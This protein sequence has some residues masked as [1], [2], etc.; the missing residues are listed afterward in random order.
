MNNQSLMD[1]IYDISTYITESKDLVSTLDKII[2]LIR[3]LFIIDNVVVYRLIQESQDVEAIY[4]RALGRGKNAEAD[5]AW[6]ELITNKVL[7]TNKTIL[8]KPSSLNMDDRLENS[9]LLAVPVNAFRNIEGSIVYIRFGGP[10]FTSEEIKLAEIIARQVSILFSKHIIEDKY[11][12]LSDRNKQV[13][14][15]EDFISNITHEL[16]TP[17]GF[18]KGYATTL[19]RPDTSWDEANQRKFLGIIDAETDH[20]L[21]LINNLLDSSRLQ[22]GQM[23]MLFQPVQLESC[24]RDVIMRT[25]MRAASIDIKLNCIKTLIPINGDPN[26]LVQVFENIVNNALKYAPGSDIDITINQSSDHT[27]ISI[28]DHGAGIPQEHLPYLFNRFYQVKDKNQPSHG[29]GL[30]LYI[31]KEIILAHHGNIEVESKIGAG[32]E[33]II[34]IPNQQPI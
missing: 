34:T 5:V 7:Q 20:L 16:R 3:Q 18:I 29:S 21:E 19:L 10:E 12:T 25:E 2:L 6:G 32:T 8:E 22:S 9:Y 28:K 13:Q 33:F 24:L 4:A 31:C 1:L 11:L 23:Q 27:I 15:Q 26:R 17:L 30:G 14:L